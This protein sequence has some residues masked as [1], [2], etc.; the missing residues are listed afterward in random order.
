MSTQ[1]L[2]EQ[3]TELSALRDSGILSEDEFVTA[4]QRVLSGPPVPA[5]AVVNEAR[6]QVAQ[7]V[8]VPAPLAQPAIAYAFPTSKSGGI[9]VH[10]A[11]STTAVV[12]DGLGT[13]IP[14]PTQ[15]SSLELTST[16]TGMKI[17]APLLADKSKLL[18]AFIMPIA[19]T[20][21]IIGCVISIIVLDIFMPFASPCPNGEFCAYE[22]MTALQCAMVAVLVLVAI[23]LWYTALMNAVNRIEIELDISAD[24]LTYSMLPL[25]QLPIGIGG[26]VHFLNIQKA[27]KELR[28]GVTLSLFGNKR[29][30]VASK[31]AQLFITMQL[32][33]THSRHRSWTTQLFKIKAVM[34]DGYVA[35]VGQCTRADGKFVERKLEEALG[36]VNQPVAGECE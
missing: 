8:V 18:I 6:P 16:P 26:L 35:E 28:S 11:P 24:T 13:I 32:T 7:A 9:R 2:A 27:R 31:I 4:K 5:A 1:S 19:V 12:T 25:P 34:K 14:L 30:V 17:V 10:P 15:S 20:V 21:S 22:M 33:V 36:I 3:I 29:T 23:S